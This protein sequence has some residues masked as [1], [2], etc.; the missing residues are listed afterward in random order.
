MAVHAPGLVVAAPAEWS[1]RVRHVLHA[2]VAAIGLVLA[3]PVMLALAIAVKLT[4]R[5]PVFYRGLRVGRGGRLFTIYKFRT[6]AVDAEARIGARLLDDRDKTRLVTPIG[7]LLKRTKLDEL[8]QL[9][10]VIRGDMRLV[11]PRPVR[12][13]FLPEFVRDIPGY[14]ARFAVPPG[15]TG[16]AQLR[17]GYYTAPR[18]KLRYDRVYLRRRSLALDCQVLFFTVV[19]ILDRWLGTGVLAV[20]LLAIVLCSPVA[21]TFG[22][23]G[24]PIRINLFVA[25]A[26]VLAAC[27]AIGPRPSRFSLYRCPLHVPMA[28]FLL[29]G[30][31]ASWLTAGERPLFGRT[32][33]SIVAGVL[34]A[35]VLVNAP[36]SSRLVAL[37]M[38]GIAIT[39]AALSALALLSMFV[40]NYAAGLSAAAAA[41]AVGWTAGAGLPGVAPSGALTLYLLLGIPLL[42]AEVSAAG[43]RRARDFWVVATTLAFAGFA[44]TQHAAGLVAVAVTVA[45]FVSQRVRAR[46]ATIAL[47]VLVVA[48]AGSAGALG[49]ASRGIVGGGGAD[50]TVPVLD[51]SATRWLLGT[52]QNESR[53]FPAALPSA[54]GAAG[55]R[56]PGPRGAPKGHL[57]LILEAGLVQWLLLVWLVVSVLRVLAAG[58]ARARAERARTALPA[59]V[60]ALAGVLVAMTS[61]DLF[62]SA[63]AQVF[64][65]SLLGIGLGMAIQARGRQ[66]NLIWRF[67]DAGD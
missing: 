50:P 28:L 33:S 61:I 51:R 21:A 36:A 63:P 32:A 34:L 53:D 19:K 26:A 55:P 64:F 12:P 18:N 35:F 4:S 42:L 23:P 17:G 22:V 20:A 38:R 11:G 27:L 10:N 29:S 43:T 16:I 31:L 46:V 7:R 40:A 67:G 8:P 60:A 37:T 9:L 6:L 1:E 45:V 54:S 14:E 48:L 56:A 24:L 5:G 15:I 2:A 57:A 66:A 39:S 47:G 58:S 65:W 25:A 49:G 44:F 30:V 62:D 41:L 3:A 13:V 59:I 52:D